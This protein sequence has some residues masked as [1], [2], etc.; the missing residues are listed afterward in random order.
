MWKDL[1]FDC[2]TLIGGQQYLVSCELAR[3]GLFIR[4]ETHIDGG[5]NIF[6]AIKTRLAYQLSKAFDISFVK[7]PKP[8]VPTGYNGKPGTPIELALILTFVLDLRRINFPF[9][10]TD[11]G[12]TDVLI[13]RKFLE[14]Y[15]LMQS[16]SKGR[17]KLIWPQDMPIT[18]YFEKRIF[19]DKANWKRPILL[20]HQKDAERRDRQLEQEASFCSLNTEAKTSTPTAKPTQKPPSRMSGYFR[21]L[22]RRIQSME[23]ILRS[24][25]HDPDKSEEKAPLS[26]KTEFENGPYGVNISAISAVAMKTCYLNQ[27]KEHRKDDIVFLCSIHDIDLELERR[28]R[29]RD[30]DEVVIAAMGDSTTSEEE[31]LEAKY[32]ADEELVWKNLPES[33]SVFRALFSK[34]ASDK[35]SEHRPYDHK[36]DLKKENDLTFEPLRKQT[37]EQ[38]RETKRYLL[39]NLHKGFIEPSSAPYAAPI[40]FVKK[41]DGSLRFCVDYRKLNELTKKDPY[42]LPL[43]DE[44][45]ARISKAKFFTKLDIQQAFHKIRMAKESED[46][47]TFRTRYGNYKYKVMPFGL[48]NGP[49]TFQRFIN[50]ILMEYL[51]DFC[52]AYI[53][54]ILIYSETREEHEIHVKRVMTVLMAH[55]LQV[56]I[57]K[58]EFF[59]T[60]TKF[61]GFI[62]GVD[63]IQVDPEK[64]S[65]INNW[66]YADNVRG[67]QSYLGFCNF[68]RRFIEGYSRITAP[69][70][71]LT[72]K[73]VPFQFDGNC[74]LAWTKLKKALTSAPILAHYN[75]EYETRLETDSS[76]GVVAGVL[77]QKQPDGDYHPVGFFSK[78]MIDAE[79]NYPIHDKEMLAIFRSFQQYKPELL[80]AQK[81]VLV[82]TDHKALEYFMTTKDLTARQARWAEFFADFHFMIMYRSG[83]TNTIADTLS[84]RTQ[85]LTPQEARK[86]EIRKQALLTEDQIDP[87]IRKEMIATLDTNS[88]S[89]GLLDKHITYEYPE[90]LFMDEED[91]N[92]KDFVTTIEA[93]YL[94]PIEVSADSEDNQALAEAD[95]EEVFLEGQPPDPTSM[96]AYDIEEYGIIDKILQ[97]N[98]TAP[99]LE[100]FRDQSQN[101]DL[102]FELKEGLLYFQGRLE[103]PLQPPELRTALIRHIHAQP[104]VAHAGGGKVKILISRKYHWKNIGA[105]I[106]QYIANCSCTRTKPRHDKTPG[107]L[108]PLPIPARPYQHLTMDFTE[109]PM[110]EEGHDFAFVV[111]DRLSKKSLSIPC[112]KEIDAK[113]MA[114][115]FVTYWVRNWGMPDSIVSDRGPQFVST[116]W[117]ELCRILGTKVK[118][119]TAY[120]PNVDGQTEIM[121]QYIKQRLRPFCTYYQDNWGQLLPVMDLAQLTLPHESLGITPFQLLNGFEPRTSWDLRN[122]EPPASATEKLNRQDAKLVAC[123]MRDAVEFAQS[124]IQSQQD[125][126]KRVANKRRREVDWDVGD[127]VLV[128]MR[129]WKLD[130]PSRKLSEKWYGPIKVLEK[131]GES[132]K[133][134][135]PKDWRVYPVF[136]SH[137]LRRYMDNPLPGQRRPEPPVI[138][139]IPEQDEYEI[140]EI[141]GSKVQ[142]GILKYRIKWT[143]ADDDLEWYPCSD[144]MGAPHK[145]KEFHLKHPTAKGPPKR[146]PDW[147]N[148]YNDG[149]DD[150]SAMEDNSLMK[151]TSARARFFEGGG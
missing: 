110:D 97:A 47:T 86:K 115:I 145:L 7:L 28:E 67:V 144:A 122:P 129:N 11:L 104:S 61:L 85:D 147:L 146:L 43:I 42:P 19:I 77:S 12:H 127:L 68:Y 84:R 23:K 22:G 59:V 89:I 75:P 149:I 29:E 35:L 30:E 31:L 141:L 26:R 137:S 52:S 81:M 71:R 96:V 27:R 111:M 140:E 55:G 150:Y 45:M 50:D 130:R 64:I 117:S 41:S 106:I 105:D 44:M 32:K 38:L 60:K 114:Q 57:K 20:E 58:S 39:N 72:G 102:D 143:G 14:H 95:S 101:G 135:L 94:A 63:G 5:A 91:Y 142:G 98:K 83:K 17:R 48:T 53:D 21:D 139:I 123:R 108:K 78:S 151:D 74:R 46:L 93:V 124:S 113:G 82:Y 25:L 131:V 103:V 125:K 33:F 132:W 24:C 120:N 62:I 126:M 40:L 66:E 36:I 80:G 54:D 73:D 16:F 134:D 136:H 133:V 90:V 138:N 8:I 70:T 118:L 4:T 1:N 51:D 56:D 18:P 88:C 2:R 76:D 116:F 119:T 107:Y 109:L 34:R 13:G 49:A 65:V 3:N 15:D 92:S 87:R 148:A 69:L 121:N 10:V 99:E 100:P 128:D 6:G 37:D 79:L 112:N 9:L